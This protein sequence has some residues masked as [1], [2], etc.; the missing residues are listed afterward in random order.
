MEL[1]ERLS[2]HDFPPN[3]K[4]FRACAYVHI[5]QP[6]SEPTLESRGPVQGEHKHKEKSETHGIFGFLPQNSCAG[7]CLNK[8][9][10]SV[11]IVMRYVRFNIISGIPYIHRNHANNTSQAPRAR[12]HTYKPGTRFAKGGEPRPA[13]RARAKSPHVHVSIGTRLIPRGRESMSNGSSSKF[14]PCK[15]QPS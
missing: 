5:D 13:N 12:L 15:G 7:L 10:P 1:S 9:I 11:F 4:G 8:S 6:I 3:R 14:Y 2:G